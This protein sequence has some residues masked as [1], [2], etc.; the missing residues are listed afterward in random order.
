MKLR[1]KSAGIIAGTLLLFSLPAFAAGK[2]PAKPLGKSTASDQ[3]KNRTQTDRLS[4][5]STPDAALPPT[6]VPEKSETAETANP[7]N[8]VIFL[9][10]VRNPND[11]TLFANGAGWDGNW[12]VGYNTCWVVKLP[13]IPTGKFARAYVG[14]RLGRMKTEAVPG[15][16][17]WERRP[18]PGEI[19]IAVAS[20]PL[21][22]QTRRFTLAVT[23]NIP[24]EGDAENAVEGVGESRW[25]WAQVPLKFLSTEKEHYVALFSPTEALKD[26][27]HSPI[28]AAGW[29][30]VQSNTWLN[31]SVR[32]QPPITV[33]EALKTGVSYF[34]PGIA[35]KLVAENSP[36]PAVAIKELSDTIVQD[37]VTVAASVS[38]AD[39]ESAWIEFSTDTKNWNRAATALTNAPYIFTVKR[40]RLLEGPVQLRVVAQ[41]VYGGQG[42]S[43][44]LDVTVMPPPPPPAKKK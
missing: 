25:F 30:D 1:R 22:P 23:E 26:A 33:E 40:D 7:S 16:P 29:G 6:R 21:W 20:E 3:A 17:P 34:K 24:L 10:D 19:Q 18:I 9:A 31:S 14:A 36:A 5:T 44:E 2:K 13:P 41:D 32:G 8:Q 15:R 42:H 43:Q 28:L 12:Y 11:F 38:G 27:A 37:K 35:I 39:V 4:V